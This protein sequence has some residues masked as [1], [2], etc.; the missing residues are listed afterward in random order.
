MLFDPFPLV[1]TDPGV[2]MRL[3]DALRIFAS[4]YIVVALGFL[5]SVDERFLGDPALEHK[6]GAKIDTPLLAVPEDAVGSKWRRG[7]SWRERDG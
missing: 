7:R 1:V 6:P 5:D 3:Q 2:P 4:R